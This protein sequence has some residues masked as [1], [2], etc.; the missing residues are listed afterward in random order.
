MGQ[1]KSLKIKET[2]WVPPLSI[3]ALEADIAYFD[4]RLALLNEKPKTYY[5]DA[6]LRACQELI[7]TLSGHVEKLRGLSKKGKKARAAKQSKK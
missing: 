7:N 3:S 5:E 6:Q 1:K 4:A 2:T